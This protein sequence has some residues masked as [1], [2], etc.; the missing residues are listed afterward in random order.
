MSTGS[1]CRELEEELAD[2]LGAN[3]VIAVASG[4]AAIELALRCLDL[5]RGARVGIPTW[6]FVATMTAVL[7]AGFTPVLLD[8]EADT[9]NVSPEALERGIAG[10]LDALV[11]V[12][13][14]GVPV[15]REVHDLCHGSEIP[16]VEDAAHALGAFDH[17][18]P[19][20]GDGSVA[21][22]FSFAATGN[23]TAGEGGAIVTSRAD[24][25]ARATALRLH[26]LTRD[27]WARFRPEE[28]AIYGLLEPG[29]KANMPDLLAALAR[30]QLGRLEDLQERRR[31]LVIEYRKQ[32]SA[33]EG[34][35][36]VPE[37]LVVDSADNLFVVLLPESADRDRVQADLRDAGVP[38]AVHFPPLHQFEALRRCAEIGRGG[39]AAA[40]SVA[41]RALSLPLHPG[42]TP[43]DIGRVAD[44]LNSV[45]SRTAVTT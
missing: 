32:L 5:P 35:R 40:D 38:S 16:V 30:S 12:H 25:A 37:H 31:R 42:M 26:G 4:T 21:A 44:A 3:Y 6:T 33:I 41:G 14:G 2:Q 36:G 9:L 18:G 7:H 8:V 29:S 27:A 10:G 13:F 1:E 28:P 20:R 17:R 24:V 45:L 34:L 15:A 23:I 22:C 43:N 11:P 19:M 39:L